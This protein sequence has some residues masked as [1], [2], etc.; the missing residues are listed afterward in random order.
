MSLKG[1]YSVS[2][3]RLARIPKECAC[4]VIIR[5]G[6]QYLSYAPGQRTR[7]SKCMQC[8][9]RLSEFMTPVYDCYD[10]REYLKLPQRRI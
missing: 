8:A 6:E 2:K 4:G 3:L 1:T 9:T 5:K 10:I 7:I